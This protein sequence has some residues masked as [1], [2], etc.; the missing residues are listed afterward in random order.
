MAMNPPF[1]RMRNSLQHYAWGSAHAIPHLLG[2]DNPSGQ[3]VA[4]YWM[5]AHPAA[6]SYLYEEGTS[7]SEAHPFD[8]CIVEAPQHYLGAV[9]QQHFGNRL[10]FLLKLLSAQQALS[11]QAH[12]NLSQAAAGYARE[13]AQGIDL[14]SPT[15]SYK[16]PSHK[17]EMVYSLTTYWAMCGFR[18]FPEIIE[19][20]SLPP[21]GQHPIIDNI[22]Q[23][24]PKRNPAAL[25]Y[26]LQRLLEVEGE[27][28]KQLLEAASQLVATHAPQI[29]RQELEER[30]IAI[31]RYWWVGELM[32]QFP[33]DIGALAPFY[34]N[35]IKLAPQQALFLGAGMLHAYLHGSAIEVMANSD[36]VLRGG[37][38][39]KYINKKE[40]INI[41]DFHP[42][43]PL[44]VEP[45]L[46]GALQRFPVAANEFEL[47]SLQL[48]ATPKVIACPSSPKIVLLLEGEAQ[49][50]AENSPVTLHRG[51]SLFLFPEV[52]SFTASGEGRLF[53]VTVAPRLFAA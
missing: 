1:L 4:E 8:Q 11:I 22:L 53:L 13:E 28:Q 37:L 35:V 29:G 21:L 34:L 5:G 49:I 7:P 41:L 44:W 33:N 20:F 6:P 24:L 17:P 30:D 26:F 38:T 52:A 47:S 46:E 31:A 23:R 27:E 9:S 19:Q 18:A 40:L 25:S 43:S 45:R 36:N 50:V 39:S 2:I 48:D 15:R 3:P 51:Q 42:Q 10:P 12:P 14:H 32:R 16:D